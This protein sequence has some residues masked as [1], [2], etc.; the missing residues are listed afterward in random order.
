MEKM[1]DGEEVKTSVVEE[2]EK[3]EVVPV[4]YNPCTSANKP[5]QVTLSDDFLDSNMPS[6]IPISGTKR[7]PC[8]LGECEEFCSFADDVCQECPESERCYHY[9]SL[10]ISH[11]SHSNQT[12]T[13]RRGNTAAVEATL[14]AEETVPAAV[15]STGEAVTATVVPAVGSVVEA[16]VAAVV[17]TVDL[18]IEE[19][20]PTID[21]SKD[22]TISPSS[23]N[24]IH[25]EDIFF[26]TRGYEE[27]KPRLN[28]NPWEEK[29]QLKSEH[30]IL[31]S[32]VD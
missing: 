25:R 7:V 31:Y 24:E 20:P 16:T 18:S 23:G 29:D 13:K 4:A 19:V 8:A 12:S 11:G 32:K 21:L 28:N 30:S 2:A 17:S 10:H 5:Q 27:L 22:D 26:T 9:C 3:S 14:P 1:I 6:P 15:Q